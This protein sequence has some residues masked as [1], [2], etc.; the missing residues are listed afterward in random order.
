MHIDVVLCGSRNHVRTPINLV[1]NSTIAMTG[2]VDF[3]FL[4]KDKLSAYLPDTI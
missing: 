1:N 2:N 3:G 4:V